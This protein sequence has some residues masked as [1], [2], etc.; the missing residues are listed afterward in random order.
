MNLRERIDH[1]IADFSPSDTQI[2]TYLL[3]HPEQAPLLTGAELAAELDLSASSITRFAQRLGFEGYPDLRRALRRVLREKQAPSV[4]EQKEGLFTAYWTRE[5]QNLEELSRTSDTLLENCCEALAN[6][7]QIWILGSRSNL[8]HAF[9]TYELLSGVRA[10][11][12]LLEPKSIISPEI[13]LETTTHDTLLVFSTRRYARATT[14]IASTL[15]TRGAKILLI[16]DNGNSPLVPHATHVI[17]VPSQA[18]QQYGAT[19]LISSLAH[20]L[21]IGT[22][23]RTDPTRRQ[24]LEELL[25]EFDVFE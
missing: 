17:R 15:K 5:K 13:L 14:Q 7:K 21:V 25:E 3:A 11:V 1:N 4:P 10:N 16:T 20:L 18:I 6:A 22:A 9:L 24:R 8:G 12:H 23:Q 19:G 2:S